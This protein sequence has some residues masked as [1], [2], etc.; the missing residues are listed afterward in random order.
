V[1][2][3]VAGADEGDRGGSGYQE[4]GGAERTT[5]VVRRPGRPDPGRGRIPGQS[6][7]GDKQVRERP[8]PA[9]GTA[10]RGRTQ[11]PDADDVGRVAEQGQGAAG[12]Q[13]AGDVPAPVQR[14]PEQNAEGRA[15]FGVLCGYAAVAVVLAVI[16][17]RRRDA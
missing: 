15:G 16:L 4:Q 7:F 9:E 10:E 5:E 17:L 14:A 2:A 13:S 3:G 1:A 12:Q 8:G 11:Q 6:D